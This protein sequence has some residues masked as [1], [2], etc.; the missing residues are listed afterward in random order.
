MEILDATLSKS[1]LA[2]TVQNE[3]SRLATDKWSQY[4]FNSDVSGDKASAMTL[5]IDRIN[6]GDPKP[7]VTRKEVMLV[8]LPLAYTHYT[9]G[10]NQHAY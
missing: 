9:I 1:L 4:T 10:T 7:I 8:C 6:Q 5:C 3:S 2:S